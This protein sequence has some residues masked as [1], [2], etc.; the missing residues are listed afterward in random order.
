MSFTQISNILSNKFSGS[1]MSKKISAALVCDE[2]NK[3]IL[4]M[5][6]KKIENQAQAMYLKDR[7]LTVAC[8]SPII[9]QELKLREGELMARLRENFGSGAVERLRVLT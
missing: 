6:G 7:I 1:L 4:I 2:F 8:L 9:G 5:W 3:I